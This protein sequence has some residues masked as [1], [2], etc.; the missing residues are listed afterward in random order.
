MKR[1]LYLSLA[2]ILA[3]TFS[4]FSCENK[5]NEKKE[6]KDTISINKNDASFAPIIM[7]N[8]S[9]PVSLK[10]LP[11]SVKPYVEKNFHGYKIEK[12]EYDPLCSGG[13]AIDVVISKTGK[14]NFSLIFTTDGTFVQKEEDVKLSSAPEKILE[15]IK[16]K[17]SDYS[18]G[19]QIEKL[20]LA[21]NTIQ[22]LVDITRVEVSKELILTVD[23]DVVC[24]K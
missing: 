4:I 5:T 20:T 13:D 18:T 16:L 23:G 1:Q 22:Y 21:D 9:G 17:Y 8:V 6:S 10:N 2:T 14:P 12:A 19:D 11:V 3:I 7:Q 24:E 15:V